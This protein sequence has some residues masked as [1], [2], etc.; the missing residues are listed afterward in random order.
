MARHGRNSSAATVKPLRA[1]LFCGAL[2]AVGLLLV[3]WIVRPTTATE[4]KPDAKPRYLATPI[5]FRELIESLKDP[6]REVR[7]EAIKYLEILNRPA[8]DT[9]P[10]LMR[11]FR[12]PDVDVRI[13]AVRAAIR[14]GMPARK[15]AAIAVQALVPE[16]PD[17]C[18][19][20]AEI[21][22]DI[23]PPARLAL[24]QLRSC[25]TASSVWV[26]MHAARA[27]LKIDPNDAAAVAVLQSARETE[28]GKA[29]EFAV[30]ALTEVA[31]RLSVR[32][33]QIKPEV[34]P[35]TAVR[36]EEPEPADA[37]KI[38]ATIDGLNASDPLMRAR[39]AQ[40]AFRAGAPA[41]QITN[42]VSGLLDP[43]H[44]DVLRLAA[45]ILAEIGPE[46]RAALPKLHECLQASSI[47]VRLQAAEATLRIDA[48]DRIALL[49]LGK[50]LKH[51]RADVRYFA[52]NALSASV[53]D[54]DQAALALHESLCD[55]D[56]K[57]ATA[58]ALLLS[59][60]H[61]LPRRGSL[62]ELLGSRGRSD[63]QNGSISSWIGELSHEDASVRRSAAICLAL[64]GP[65]ANSAVPEL[66]DR[67]TDR[68]PVVRLHAAHALW[69]ISRDGA[70]IMPTL[71]DL[72]L[73]NSG[74]T[75]IGAILTLGRMGHAAADALHRLTQTLAETNS[76]E[77]LLIAE[78]IARIEPANREAIS[79]LVRGLHSS[80]GDARYLAT[81]ALGAVPLA[82]QLAAEEAL[83]VSIDDRS[84]RV[85]TAA[86]ETL[87]QLVVRHALART[88]PA[89][90]QD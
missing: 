37:G 49:E 26:R 88:A 29:Q 73:T 10:A 18:C 54:S 22:G 24:P 34:R 80:S 57:V 17:A 85:R 53:M 2:G 86:Y 44:L 81:V 55:P 42:A 8:A 76:V 31:D 77:R 48:T 4:S 25:L 12:D 51:P 90:P 35:A 13:Q 41:V 9:V 89:A 47:A 82:K 1:Y 78:S 15:G 63:L 46:A 72:L 14:A 59:R 40:T 11:V 39:A 50:D 74:G 71:V 75:R 56:P 7:L 83:C 84:G 20:G 45:S 69:E 61:D 67:Q 30:Q 38:P 43:E 21:L 58:A 6:R 3:A 36:R 68:D 62:A 23:G 64:A 19:L 16:H 87:S 32:S 60:T 28:E 70:I 52:V 65:A 66:A 27:I 33:H 79:V 5:S